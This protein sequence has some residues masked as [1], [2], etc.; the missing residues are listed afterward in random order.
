MEQVRIEDFSTGLLIVQVLNVIFW[1]AVIY[2]LYKHF[3]RKKQ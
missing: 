3:T 2:L 1:I